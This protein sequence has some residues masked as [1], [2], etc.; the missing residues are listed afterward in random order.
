MKIRL[1]DILLAA[2][3]LAAALLLLFVRA[4]QDAPAVAVVLRG[5]EEIARINLQNPETE[6]V[7]IDEPG[8]VIRIEEGRIRFEASSCPDQTC[9]HTG[10]LSRAG[11]I[12]V[13][14]PNEVIVKVE[15]GETDDI[16]VVAE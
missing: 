16:D 14:L 4:P 2:A 8:I 3:A 9:V 15:G 10:W 6:E 12:A 13:C 5:G 11:D 1:G 7:R